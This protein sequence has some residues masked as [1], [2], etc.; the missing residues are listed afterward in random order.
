MK[1]WIG[2]ILGLATG[3]LTTLI[4]INNYSIRKYLSPVAENQTPKVKPLEKYTIET[5]RRREFKPSQIILDEQ[6]ASAQDFTTHKF[7][8]DSDGKKITGLVH[9]P[10]GKPGQK[11]PAIVQFRGFVEKE[12]YAPGI[13]TQRSAEVF[14]Q[15]GFISLAPDFL[16]YGGSASPSADVFAERFETYTT[17]LNLLASV[18]TLP[19][20]DAGKVGIWGHS[21]G[22]QIALTVLEIVNKS[23]PTSVWAPVT[24]PFPYSILYYTDEFDDRGKMLR[25]KLAQFESMYDVELYSMRNYLDYIQSPLQLHQGTQDDAVPKKWSDEFVDLIQDKGKTIAY[26]T[27]TGA[28]HNLSGSWKMVVARDVDFFNKYLR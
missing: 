22:G 2:L 26:Y 24:K 11:F 23:Y 19:Q 18:S 5:L 17:A 27:Y 20:T 8:F 25:Q 15:N 14:A 28:D 6:I 1:I 7:H 9:I 10:I 16:G 3:S 12:K 21:N 13:G 4:F